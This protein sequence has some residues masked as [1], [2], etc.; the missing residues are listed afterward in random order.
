LDWKPELK[1]EPDRQKR[2][3]EYKTLR[4]PDEEKD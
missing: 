3:A 1:P 2:I 4:E